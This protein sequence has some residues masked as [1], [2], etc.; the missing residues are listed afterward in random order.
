MR[1]SRFIFIALVVFIFGLLGATFFSYS[2]KAL[3]I[4]ADEQK[5]E[6]LYSQILEGANTAPASFLI[7]FSKPTSTGSPLIF[8]GSHSPDLN[9]QDAWN[10]IAE[11]GVTSI[12]KD[13]YPENALPKNITLEEYK[14][15]LGQIQNPENWNQE[16]LDKING[17]YKNAHIRGM[18]TIGIVSFSPAWLNYSNTIYGVPKD[19]DVYEDIVRKTYTI[20]RDNLDYVELWNEPNFNTFLNTKDSGLTKDEAYSKIFFHAA[21]AIRQVDAEANDGKIIPIGGPAGY[22]PIQTSTLETI[23]ENPAT[24]DKLNFVSYHNYESKHLIE[25]SWTNY[26]RVM[27]KYGKENLPIY[28]TEWN[29]EPDSSVK[30]PFNTS[31]SAI[32]FTGNKFVSFLRMGLAGANYHVLWPLDLT[33]PDKG[34]G[35]MGFYRWENG[36]AELLPQAKTWRLM[37]NKMGLGKGKSSIYN[38]TNNSLD[39]NGLGFINTAKQYGA[40]VVNNDGV[41]HMANITLQNTN[42]NHIATVAVYYASADND[43]TKPIYE[44]HVKAVKG[45]INLQVYLPKEAVV[46]VIVEQDKEWF[47]FLNLPY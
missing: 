20:Y 26:M 23:L 18:K 2:Q 29:Y 16:E 8:G 22:D 46:G 40:V 1:S 39:L 25:P 10:K 43:A 42:I 19:W 35:Y 36:K 30:S 14:N 13:F 21:K 41:S 37:S 33:R 11:I 38:P 32:P 5:R 47:D 27:E 6:A 31:N 15:N 45:T 28:I 34:E 24:R 44:G 17:I 7:N 12:R 9:H 3:Q 4:K